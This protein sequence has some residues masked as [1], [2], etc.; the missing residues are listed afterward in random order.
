MFPVIQG[1]SMMM[2]YHG[3]DISLIY[4]QNQGL[5]LPLTLYDLMACGGLHKLLLLVF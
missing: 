4:Y 1:I 5:Q 3:M 2:A